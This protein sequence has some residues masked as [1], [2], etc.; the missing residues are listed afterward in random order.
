[1]TAKLHLLPKQEPDSLVVEFLQDALARA[2]AGETR[3]V[4]LVEQ[5]AGGTRYSVSN[6]DNR[7]EVIGMLT[8]AAFK[9]QTDSAT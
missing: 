7:M 5:D 4:L 3:G 2:K 1:M 9:M 8:H 6:L